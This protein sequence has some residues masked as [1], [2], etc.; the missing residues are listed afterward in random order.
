MLSH[1]LVSPLA[2]TPEMWTD[3]PPVWAV[4]GYEMLTDSILVT[5]RR[6]AKSGTYVE[7]VGY[8]GM[9]HC[10]GMV[11]PG[12]PAARDCFARCAKFCVDAVQGELKDV[13]GEKG[14]AKGSRA[15]WMKARSKPLEF[16]EVE[17]EEISSLSEEEVDALMAEMKREALER[18]GRE[19]RAWEEE[20]EGGG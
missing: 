11:F 9:P 16:R 4:T 15:L 14:M 6:I 19:V 17:F 12:T 13:K 10:F 8:E 1:P 7:C 20:G 18:E 2:A 3:H 5:A